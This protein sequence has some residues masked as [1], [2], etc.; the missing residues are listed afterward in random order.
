MLLSLISH[1]KSK[2]PH[3]GVSSAQAEITTEYRLVRNTDKLVTSKN[4]TTYLLF[5]ASNENNQDEETLLK[6]LNLDEASVKVF[7]TKLAAALRRDA[8][9]ART[10]TEIYIKIRHRLKTPSNR[11][12]KS[13]WLG[14]WEFLT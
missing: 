9:G 2:L 12:G 14:L 8:P 13:M 10:N 5:L 3:T 4:R 7:Q 1:I 11:L 6:G